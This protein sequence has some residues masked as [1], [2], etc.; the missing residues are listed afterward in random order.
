MIEKEKIQELIK[1]QLPQAKNETIESIGHDIIRDAESVIYSMIRQAVSQE[2]EN[3]YR[4][5]KDAD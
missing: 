2:R 5:N 3:L 4:K 1:S